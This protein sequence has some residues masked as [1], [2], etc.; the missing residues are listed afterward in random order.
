MTQI[1]EKTG[2]CKYVVIATVVATRDD[3]K[4][5]FHCIVVLVVAIIIIIISVVD[6]V[7]VVVA[8]VVLIISIYIIN[9]FK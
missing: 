7:E 9:I 8:V 4:N 2:I 3:V 6:G 5:G 1:R